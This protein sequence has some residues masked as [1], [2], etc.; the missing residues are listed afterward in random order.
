MR[1][2]ALHPERH[3]GLV[4]QAA[5]FDRDKLCVHAGLLPNIV[6][7]AMREQGARG[8]QE[9][10]LYVNQ[11]FR[12]ALVKRERIR[13]R[14]LPHEI[15]H[16]GTSH[17]KERRLPGE[18]GYE[19]AGI[20]TPDLREVD[21]Y[22]YHDKL[23]AQVIGHTASKN[24]EIRYSPGSWLQRDYIAIDAGRQDG[25]GNAGLLPTRF[26]WGAVRP[27]R[28]PRVGQV[29]PLFVRLA[30]EAAAGEKSSEDEAEADV[31]RMLTTYFRSAKSERRSI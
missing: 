2:A 26:G 17:A 13:A 7:V 8:A 30:H 9:I 10:A 3:L 23:L 4:V 25:T 1:E 31:R 28:P 21:H 12:H 29:G 19:P 20:F 27:R 22:R 11:V 24:G 6:D 5:Y 16:I 18:I 15:F 14:D